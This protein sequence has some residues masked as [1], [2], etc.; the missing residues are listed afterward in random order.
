[1][2]INGMNQQRISGL[3]GLRTLAIT[4]VTFFHMF[5]NVIKGGYL[6]VS[7]FFVITGFLLAYTSKREYESGRFNILQ[8]YRKRIKRIYP[9]LIIMLLTTIGVYSFLAPD[10]IAAIRPEVESIVLGYNNWWQIGQN[11]DYFTRL[12]NTSP[13]THMWFMGIE[14]QYYLVWPVLFGLSVLISSLFGKKAGIG[15]MALLGIGTAAIMPMMYKPDLDVTRLYY[16]TDTRVYALL[17]GAAMGL[18]ISSGSKGAVSSTAS[19]LL[20]YLTAFAIFVITLVAY[21]L[22]DG[23]MEFVYQGGMLLMTIAFCLLL[24]ITTNSN[25][26]LGEYLDNSLFKW[27]GKRSY[28]IF[29]WQ[30]PVIY[31][32]HKMHWDNWFL[33]PVLEL[34][35]ILVLT[36]WSD[37]ISEAV[38]KFEIPFSGR[39]FAIAGCIALCMVT[40]PA[41]VLMGYG[42]KGIIVSAEKKDNGSEQLKKQLEK[43]AEALKEQNK[44]TAVQEQAPEKTQ[45]VKPVNLENIVCVGDSIMLSAS[46]ELQKVLPNCYIDAKVSRY[47]AGGADV[48]YALVGQGAV[49]DTVVVSLGTNGPICGAEQYEE[50]TVGLIQALGPDRQIFWVNVYCPD[51]SWQNDNNAYINKMAAEHKNIH[52]VDWYSQA[53][54]HPEWLGGDGIHPNDDGTVQYARIVKEKIVEV[55]SKK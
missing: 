52:V 4:G 8:Y 39:R 48:V 50:M 31:I 5:P 43:N 27:I 51:I 21:M 32:F 38:T 26:L 36:V 1:M 25:L 55:L 47:V 22:M 13:F 35:I 15:F 10:V 33:Y 28:G 6:G 37:S 53:A 20:Q 45:V 54:K 23:K 34:G 44:V 17:L 7:L 3:D 24:K 30:Y 2:N 16:G 46:M 40:V 19:S 12:T 41:T 18:G 29:L 11:A 14:L 42:C 49:G 9:S